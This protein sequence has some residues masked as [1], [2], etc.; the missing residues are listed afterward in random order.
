L[1]AKARIV[2]AIIPDCVKFNRRARSSA[3]NHQT[4]KGRRDI[5]G[6]AIS[7]ERGKLLETMNAA[8]ATPNGTAA[9]A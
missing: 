5:G 9:A 1:V 4:R 6:L 8:P 2:S 7:G 3:N